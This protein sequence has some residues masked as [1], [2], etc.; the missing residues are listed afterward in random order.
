MKAIPIEFLKR[1]N[2]KWAYLEAITTPRKAGEDS[3][4]SIGK[5][6]GENNPQSVQHYLRKLILGGF[7]YRENNTYKFTPEFQKSLEELEIISEEG[8]E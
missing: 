8:K 1:Q 7:I 3:L 5:M 4:R 6:V 2:K